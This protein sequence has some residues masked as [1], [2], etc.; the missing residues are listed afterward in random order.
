MKGLLLMFKQVVIEIMIIYL[1][2]RTLIFLDTTDCNTNQSSP[3]TTGNPYGV[4]RTEGFHSHPGAGGQ[5]RD[6]GQVH[7]AFNL[8]SPPTSTLRVEHP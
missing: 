8:V 2:K 4:S 1:G 7:S 6:G 3:Q 5:G